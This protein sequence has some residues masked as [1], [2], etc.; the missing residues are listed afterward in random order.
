MGVLTDTVPIYW[1]SSGQKSH[2][3]MGAL[4]TSPAHVQT[5][6]IPVLEATQGQTDV[7]FDQS[8]RKNHLEEVASVGY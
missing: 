6:L 7:S 8:P 2:G 4:L 1:P 3:S 5:T